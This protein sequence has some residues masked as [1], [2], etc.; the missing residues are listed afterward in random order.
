MLYWFRRLPKTP[1]A[2]AFPLMP[3]LMFQPKPEIYPLFRVQSP[4]L[5]F[6]YHPLVHHLEKFPLG[7]RVLQSKGCGSPSVILVATPPA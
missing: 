6:L 4:Y 2:S 1:V 3:R 5:P 7:Y